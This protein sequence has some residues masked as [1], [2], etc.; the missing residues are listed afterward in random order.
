[1][2]LL[3]FGYLASAILNIS[4]PNK[5]LHLGL[6][7]SLILF[8]C[9]AW[10]FFY[11]FGIVFQVVLL[12][13]N[14]I[15]GLYFNPEIRLYVRDSIKGLLHLPTG[16]KILSLII[17]LIILAKS[18]SLGAVLDN[19]NYYIQT[20]K[21]LNNY[22]FVDGL[23]N[24]HLFFGQTSGWHVMQSVFSFHFLNIDF[25]DLGGFLLLMLNLYAIK[26]FGKQYSFLIGL[27][28][29]NFLLLEF[30]IVPSPD[31]GVMFIA[32][33]MVYQF[34]RTYTQPKTKDFLV[35][36]VLF[37]SAML[38]KITAL[39]LIIL[40][41]GLLL[42]LK[43]FNVKTGFTILFLAIGVVSL[44]ICKNLVITGYPLF[45]SVA[46]S[47]LFTFEHQ[48]PEASYNYSLRSEKLLEFFAS[49]QE[50]NT[51]S[52]SQLLLQWLTH[53]RIGLIFNSIS[54]LLVFV[55]PLLLY[56]IKLNAKYWWLYASFIVQLVFLAFTSPQ[57]RF[58]LHYIFIFGLLVFGFVIK[59]PKLKMSLLFISQ[60]IAVW[61]LIFPVRYNA[62]SS[63]AYALES[64]GFQLKNIIV[65]AP[66]SS[67]TSAYEK[68]QM[69]NLFYNSPVEE[70]Y[71]W[72]NGDGELP[73]VN[74]VQLQYLKQKTGCR[75]Q[76]IDNTDLS[77]GFYGEKVSKE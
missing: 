10:A 25:N 28:L 68:Q 8:L 75:P 21:W 32:L 23:A 73:C 69:G 11:G 34:I 6:G 47:S 22:G 60:A 63:K 39:G 62:M 5:L 44:W 45:P 42:R 56:K 57:Y 54:L 3:N 15:L 61:F 76:L 33:L 20:I 2:T 53:S 30:T 43:R 77:Q 51:L 52:A 17:S 40:P 46:F 1:V 16:L 18:A 19:E 9:H 13:L 26:F 14:V 65:P 35:I 41:L 48:L 74:E 67:I 66:N 36:F 71:F 55:V 49:T 31:F 72:S 24:L 58:V 50:V 27:P 29:L 70:V 4:K 64:S 38:F 37:L 59:Y 7:L 12:I